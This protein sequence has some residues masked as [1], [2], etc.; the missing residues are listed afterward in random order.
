[1]EKIIYCQDSLY[2][3]ALSAIRTAERNNG[4]TEEQLSLNQLTSHM[5][6]YFQNTT[7]RLANQ[8]PLI[9]QHHVLN[10]FKDQLINHMIRLLEGRNKNELLEERDGLSGERQRLKDKIQLARERLQ[11]YLNQSD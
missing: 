11:R 3:E 8:V 6:A 7:N 5:E 2:S 10:E 9:I 4:L 1:M